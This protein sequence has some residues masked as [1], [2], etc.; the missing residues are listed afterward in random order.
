MTSTLI[1]LS[2]LI[3]RSSTLV[4]IKWASIKGVVLLKL[5]GGRVQIKMKAFFVLCLAT[6]V[7]SKSFV[8]RPK[9]Q[10]VK[11]CVNV[12]DEG[13]INGQLNGAGSDDNFLNGGFNPGKRCVNMWDEGCINGQL[14]GAGGDDNFLNGGFNPGKRCVNMW[15]EGCI[16]GQLGGAGGDDNFLNGGFNPGKRCVN[17]WDEGCINGQLGG[18]GGDDNFL[19]G[20]FNPGKRS[21]QLHDL[22]VKLQKLH[23]KN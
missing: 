16:N 9:T 5:I 2:L 3:K 1:I 4:P 6:L 12:W 22:L 19:N 8:G 15:D 17:M 13:C 21:L 18:A 14:G 11:R 23:K 10:N 20:G 7:Y